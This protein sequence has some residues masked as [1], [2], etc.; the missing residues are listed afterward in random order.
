MAECPWIQYM[1]QKQPV[2]MTKREEFLSI[3]ASER[4]PKSFKK[5]LFKK[6]LPKMSYLQKLSI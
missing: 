5:Q 1:V 4:E 6:Q 3:F 2:T